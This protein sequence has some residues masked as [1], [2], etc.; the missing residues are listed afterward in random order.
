[1]S[2]RFRPPAEKITAPRIS[3]S[4]S[5]GCGLRPPAN[6]DTLQNAEPN[7]TWMDMLF[8]TVG[9]ASCWDQGPF[10]LK[11]KSEPSFQ[12]LCAVWY[13]RI[14]PWFPRFTEN[15]CRRIFPPTPWWTVVDRAP[16]TKGKGQTYGI[17]T[18]TLDLFGDTFDGDQIGTDKGW[19]FGS[20]GST[21]ITGLSREVSSSSGNW[22]N[23]SMISSAMELRWPGHIDATSRRA[24]DQWSDQWGNVGENL[25]EHPLSPI[26]SS[27]WT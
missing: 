20:Q 16:L 8:D 22:R 27:Y 19:E 6:A 2:E 23:T 7:L 4:I 1:M 17:W 5:W 25:P 11:S 13:L 15:F 18:A 24:V 21:D 14:V 26:P 12:S 9:K 3:L 10:I